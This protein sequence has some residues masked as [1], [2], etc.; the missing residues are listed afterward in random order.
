MSLE[1]EFSLNDKLQR[2]LVNDSD[3]IGLSTLPVSDRSGSHVLLIQKA[4]NAFANRVGLAQILETGNYDQ[5]TADLVV[6]YKEQHNPPLLNFE[7]QIDAIVGKKTIDA[8]DKELPPLG[9]PADPGLQLNSVR[10]WLNAFIPNSV[11]ML[12]GSFFVIVVPQPPLS[13]LLFAGDQREFSDD[14]NA[15]SRMHSEVT[16]AGLSTD[17]PTIVDEKQICGE[18]LEI[19]EDGNVLRRATAPT[20]RMRFNNLRGSQT[21]DPEGGGIIDGIPGSVQIDFS[22]SASLPLAIA[23]DIDYSGTLVIDR[24]GGNILVSGATDGFPAYEMYCSINSGPVITLAHINPI[25]PIELMGSENQPFKVS[26]RI[27]L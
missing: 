8:L 20:D 24:I 26:A 5:A 15:F 17:A 3:H 18:S 25:G 21:L 10:F 4:L 13:L 2:C 12:K 9:E 22:G 14:P 16:I 7:N 23:P 1:S 19:D 6:T 11:C 27:V